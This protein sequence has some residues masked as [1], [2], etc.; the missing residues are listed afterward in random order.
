VH[1]DVEAEVAQGPGAD[2]TGEAGADDDNVHGLPSI[3]RLRGRRIPTI[4]DPG[5]RAG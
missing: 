5:H 1:D 4:V 2:E 3:G